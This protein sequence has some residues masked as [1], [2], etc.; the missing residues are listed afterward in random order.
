MI[1]LVMMPPQSEQSLQWANRLR[2]ELPQ[3][4]ITLPETDE[5]AHNDLVDADAVFGWVPP[6]MLAGAQKLRWLQSPQAGPKAGFYYPELVEHPVVVCNPRGVY[7]DHI[8]QH[9]LMYMLALARGLPYYMDA[10]RIPQWDKDARKSTYIDLATATVLIVG[11][12]GIGHETARLCRAFGMRVIGIDERWE[13][14]VHDVEK[15]SPAELDGSIPEADFVVVTTPHT[16]DTEGMWNADRF[17][18]MKKSAYFINIGRGA[19]TKLDDLTA[20]VENGTIAGCALDVYEV[21][22]FPTEHK[23]W[24]L[25]NV[26][27]TPH[28]AVKDAENIPERWFNVFLENARRFAANEPLKNV[29]DKQMWY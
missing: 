9:I 1:K 16:P 13:H 28:I 3:Y 14:E 21:E 5:D 20:A 8:G 26:I 7:N 10:Q 22:P 6:D 11:V 4:H 24:T 18:L 29:V 17:G 15:R 23:L 2:A 12:G 19:T 25:P 27:L